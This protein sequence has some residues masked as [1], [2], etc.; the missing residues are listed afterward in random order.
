M[1]GFGQLTYVPDDN[2]EAYLEANGMGNGTPNDDSVLTANINTVTTLVIQYQNISDLTGIEDFTALTSLYC[3]NNQ[4]TSL[5]VSQNTA[6]TILNC[7]RNNLQDTLDLTSNTLLVNLRCV[8][9]NITSLNV[10]NCTQLTSLYCYQNLLSVLDI[11][12]NIN[13]GALHAESNNLDSLN[14]SNNLLLSW[15]WCGMNNLTE[16]DLSNNLGMV[17][18]RCE[19]NQ[20]TSLDLSNHPNLIRFQAC[21][22]QLTS[23]DIRNGNNINA[24]PQT[25]SNPWGGHCNETDG[26]CVFNNPSLFCVN[27]DDSV[28]SSTSWTLHLDTQTT[29]STNCPPVVFGCTDSLA[30]NYNQLAT[31]EDSSCCYINI[32]QN[33]TAICFGDSVVLSVSVETGILNACNLPLSLQNGLTAYYPFCGN[34]DDISSNNRHLINAGTVPTTDRYGNTNSAY[35]FDGGDFLE[36]QSFPTNTSA[37]TYSAWFLVDSLLPAGYFLGWPNM[38]GVICHQIG[39]NGIGSFGI[40]ITAGGALTE[41]IY[42]RHRVS[43]PPAYLSGYN[44]QNNP[45][46]GWKH[47]ASTWDGNILSIYIDG[48]FISDAILTSS[49]PFSPNFRVGHVGSLSTGYFVGDIDDVGVWDRALTA[50]EVQQL[51]NSTASNNLLWSTGDTTA[52]ITVSPSQ[53]TTYWVTKNGCTDSATV[54]VLPSIIF[55]LSDTACESY[56][57]NGQV[58]TTSVIDSAVFTNAN[59]CD[60]VEILNLTIAVCGCIDTLAC[61]YNPSATIDDGSCLTAWG[62]MDTTACNYDTTATCN[63]GSCI[64]PDGC[65]DTTACNYNPL[66]ICDDGLCDGLLG[67]TDVT[68]CNYD[69]AATCDDGSCDGLLGCTDSTACNYD[70]AATCDD[71]S[72]DGLLGC[73]DATAC[74]YD[75]AA[76]C[77]DGSCTYFSGVV[78]IIPISATLQVQVISGGTIA[79]YEFL[80]NDAAAQTT[81]IIMANT[82]GIYTCTVTDGNQCD[83]TVTYEFLIN[84]IETY[85]SEKKLLKVTDV[86]GRETKGTSNQPLFYIYDDGTVEK[87]IVID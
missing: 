27:V 68:A 20:I 14:L 55:T 10:T 23:L 31:I 26:F 62:C 3:K 56:T 85:I 51:F 16:L 74:N 36:S 79:D 2:F 53:T 7:D 46:S 82:P 24:N 40:E 28:W 32:I 41:N 66:A 50:T 15:L 78:Q 35:Y 87:R 37:Y 33:D 60:S 71:G 39:T 81:F 61:N 8:I 52:T 38:G 43:G 75:V 83:T 1:V 86:L 6:L 5:D 22:N 18:L 34:T 21:N 76:T 57:W 11:S 4:L 67:C 64:L 17:H 77:D 19:R 73:V 48:V 72:C 84:G 80:W 12:T 70:L 30:N 45:L 44:G 49:Y 13:L 25:N 65:T 54:T 58:Y 69:V 29:F 63:D 9:N 42:A 59:G 47:A